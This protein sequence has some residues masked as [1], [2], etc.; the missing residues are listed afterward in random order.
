MIGCQWIY[1]RALK[2]KTVSE[3]T[4]AALISRG[5]GKE[6][7][8]SFLHPDFTSGLHDPFLL[9]DMDKAVERII[10]AIKTHEK[11][12]IY[13]DYDIDGLSA[14]A[15]MLDTLT[16]FGAEVSVYIPDR[17]EE[18]YGLN[19]QALQG[20]ADDKV[21]L[22]ITVDCGIT[23]VEPIR[24][25]KEAGLD[26]IVT[27]H[28]SPSMD[29]PTEA[30][31]LINPRL[32]TSKYP[33]ADLAGVG[34]AFKLATALQERLPGIMPQGQ[35][36]WLL[37]LVALGTVC[38]VAPL[39]GEN[40]TLVLFG[41]K[42]LARTR[43]LGIRAL[44]YVCGIDLA[45]VRSADLGFRLGPRL[46]AA[47]RLS[48]ASLALDLLT[49]TDS[50]SAKRLA[51]ELNTLNSQRQ[52]QTATVVAQAAAMA[53]KYT[54]DRILVLA[55]P[56]WSH[57]IV[58]I[59]AARLAEQFGKPVILLQPDGEFAKGSAR[60]AGDF[61]IIDAISSVADKLEK[62][63]GHRYAAG[64]TIKT[65]LIDDF[66]IAINS[67][68]ADS[69][70]SIG[71]KKQI[72]IDLLLADTLLSIEAAQE[73]LLLEPHGSVSPQPI[74]SSQL[75]LQNVRPVG[76]QAKHLKISFSTQ[77]GQMID[78]IAFS[79]ADRWPWLENGKSVEV[80]YQLTVNQWR[81][82]KSPQLE[83]IDIKP[84]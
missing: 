71:Q 28:H 51:G 80:A 25:A 56:S 15:L 9:P 11:I 57:G 2:P 74:I 63:G 14:C 78:G 12:I 7:H 24:V 83:I 68:A 8:A 61:S 26:V 48:H 79:A 76:S 27:D 3:L 18:G 43:R 60:S 82:T 44:A 13:G 4:T 17:F 38:D 84:A 45:S 50:A 47:G 77:N 75:T 1:D 53:E 33:Y 66:R 22:V 10:Q 36:K 30:T 81:D 55:D 23:A 67:Y 31:A 35:E 41:L 39:T 58:G 40:R 16:Q 19:S 64:L 59:A 46:N 42:V 21:G 6:Q 70:D 52:G 73:L 20:L 29:L 62:F 54:N 32:P 49:T 65:S 37:D 5:I 72:E 34:V 69:L